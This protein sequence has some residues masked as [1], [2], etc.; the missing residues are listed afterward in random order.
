[1]TMSEAGRYAFDK[2]STLRALSMAFTDETRI[3]TYE[4]IEGFV[5]V[6]EYRAIL[7]HSLF[8]SPLLEQG[9]GEKTRRFL[10]ARARYI[11]DTHFYF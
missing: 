2:R 8:Y 1:M 3:R 11:G 10:R 5:A 4:F 6:A 9:R 7:Q